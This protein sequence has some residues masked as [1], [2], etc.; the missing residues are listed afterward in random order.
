MNAYRIHHT[1]ASAHTLQNLAPYQQ[2]TIEGALAAMARTFASGDGE[3]VTFSGGMLL[4]GHWI[5]YALN[6]EARV[7]DVLG[8]EL[9]AEALLSRPISAAA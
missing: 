3:T 2:R 1:R 6:H 9:D 7:L 4:C 5:A 8:I